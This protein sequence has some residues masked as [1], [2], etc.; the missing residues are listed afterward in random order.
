[1][2]KLVL[3]D[4]VGCS[5]VLDCTIE[6][7]VVLCYRGGGVVKLVFDEDVVGCSCVKD[8]MVVCSVVLGGVV[9]LP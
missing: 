2:A 7:R 3:D 6:G 4:V 8:D 5:S 1:M 9:V